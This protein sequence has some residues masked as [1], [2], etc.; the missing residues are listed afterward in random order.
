MAMESNT[1]S[2]FNINTEMG[3]VSSMNGFGSCSSRR[4]VGE[5]SHNAL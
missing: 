2:H 5:K 4:V 1:S 3:T